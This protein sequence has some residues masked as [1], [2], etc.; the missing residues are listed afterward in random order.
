MLG[1]DLRDNTRNEEIG[2]RTD[3]K[4]VIERYAKLKWSSGHVDR[5]LLEWMPGHF[6]R[7]RR[8]NLQSTSSIRLIYEFDRDFDQFKVTAS[9]SVAWNFIYSTSC[10]PHTGTLTRYG[11]FVK[12]D[13]LLDGW[14]I[15]R[16]LPLLIGL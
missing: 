5:L 9:N 13:H 10:S 16:E 11:V 3:I 1:V 7:F 4:A 15:S 8:Q 14:K 6:K 12:E 2:D